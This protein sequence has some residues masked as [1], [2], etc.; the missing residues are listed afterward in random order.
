MK[1]KKQFLC[2]LLALCFIVGWQPAALAAA[3][4]EAR[5]SIDS[6]ATWKTCSLIDAVWEYYMADADVKVEL[7]RDVVLTS[8]NWS[9]GTILAMPDQSVE[10]DGKG[11]KLQRG[12]GIPKM[13]SVNQPGSTVTLKNIVVDGGAVWSGDDPAT[14]KN[15]GIALGGNAHLFTV[16]DGGTL[17]LDSGAVLQNSHLTKQ[18]M[19]GGAVS[20]G[21]S[22]SGT[23]VMRKGS[24]IKDCS[25]FCGT[26]YVWNQGKFIMEG[27]TISGN[28]A[29]N[30]GGAVCLG[31]GEMEMKD[32][33]I[34]GNKAGAGGG[35]VSV[36]AAG[37]ML[38]M[39]GGSITG[40]A[41]GG[42]LG[43]GVLVYQGDMTVSGSPVIG[44]NLD[45]N[46]LENNTYL[47][48]GKTIVIDP[49]LESGASIGVTTEAT[50]TD[51]KP[52]EIVTNTDN[53]KYQQYFTLDGVYDFVEDDNG[54]IQLGVHT[55][56][57][58]SD[59]WV[60]DENQHWHACSKC[61]IKQDA[62]DHALADNRCT[63]CGY[64]KPV[65]PPK[66]VVP[67]APV[68]IPKT[69]DNSRLALWACLALLSMAGVL[70]LARRQKGAR[71]Q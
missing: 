38:I 22:G 45:K 53:K 54:K 70:A 31:G 51:G 21:T 24:E 35:G 16:D 67:T 15:T 14:R 33:D 63:V 11:H 69:G 62:A 18:D 42:T 7:L 9:T 12:Q 2:L 39:S 37:S 3:T 57:E 27:G 8:T 26:V 1:P 44:N 71:G 20:V 41:I 66:P 6:G 28:Y 30:N 65:A 36:F 4:D 47:K 40:N 19:Y 60:W 49:Q 68:E 29:E 48:K 61:G 56:H 58:Y 64:E 59:N 32:G 13:F 10:I 52:V 34:S 43:G 50:P 17:I 23:L 5:Y 25:T 55:N 46:G